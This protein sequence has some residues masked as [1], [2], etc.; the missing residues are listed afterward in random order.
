MVVDKPWKR[1]RSRVLL[2]RMYRTNTIE[3]K[4]FNEPRY[5]LVALIRG[6]RLVGLGP[7]TMDL[8]T[9]HREKIQKAALE[10]LEDE[11]SILTRLTVPINDNAEWPGDGKNT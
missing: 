6:T 5:R 11:S 1:F 7:G 9:S 4:D 10:V 3:P 2:K 8:A